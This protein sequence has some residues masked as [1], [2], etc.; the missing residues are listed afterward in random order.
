MLTHKQAKAKLK[1]LASGRYHTIQYAISEMPDSIEYIEYGLYI[2]GT[3][4]VKS[5]LSWEEALAGMKQKL[6]QGA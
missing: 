1:K 5:R 3:G 6:T 2:D 4:W